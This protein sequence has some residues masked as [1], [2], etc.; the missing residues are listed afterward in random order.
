MFCAFV[1]DMPQKLYICIHFI[2][3]RMK[4]VWQYD[5]QTNPIYRGKIVA[6]VDYKIYDFAD[7][8]EELYERLKGKP[9]NYYTFQVPKNIG[10]VRILSLKIKSL[11]NNLWIPTYPV[12][13]PTL[14]KK[15]D[16]EALLVDSG[17]DISLVTYEFGK[18][19]GFQRT[20]QDVILKAQGVGST[21]E[22]LMKK[23]AITI[24]GVTF[25][26][27]FAW[28]QDDSIE[29]MILGR[30]V[31]FDLFDITFKQAEESIIFQ[32]RNV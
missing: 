12:Y 8:Y 23:V 2:V 31:V 14:D 20:P 4:N 29:D 13:F 16:K 25:D 11:K 27:H 17:A 10:A 9:V 18:R 30:E 15:G 22:Y 1:G 28:V 5:I 24:E 7:T 32:P 6:V 3:W 19:L 21:I 26:N